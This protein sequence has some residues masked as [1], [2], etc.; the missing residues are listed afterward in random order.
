MK[1]ILI[2]DDDRNIV[3]ALKK[4]LEANGYE[5]LTAYDGYIALKIALE[6][7]V[8][9]LLLDIWMPVGVG[10]SVA[11]RLRQ[12][13]L[14]IPIIYMTASK[15]PG[16]SDAAMKLGAAGY[17]EKPYDPKLL[18]EL[19]EQVLYGHAATAGC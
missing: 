3:A 18:L 10:L 4:R 16:L 11:E 7:Q 14:D 13:G 19:I 9:L 1:T 5:V 17:I 2:A 6:E 8:D 12:R 15:A